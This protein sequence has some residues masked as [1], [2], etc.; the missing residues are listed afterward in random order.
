MINGNR[1]RTVALVLLVAF[2]LLALAHPLLRIAG[3]A[4]SDLASL[5]DAERTIGVLMAGAIGV[6]VGTSRSD[7][8]K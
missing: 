4:A 2:V 6:N 8:S 7:G 5:D 3:A 1:G